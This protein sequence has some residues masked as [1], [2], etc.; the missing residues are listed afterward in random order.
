[1]A[2]KPISN[3]EEIN[4]LTDDMVLLVSRDGKTYSV[5]IK[6]LRECIETGSDN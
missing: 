2:N 3:F 5:T 6:T 1:M 4:E